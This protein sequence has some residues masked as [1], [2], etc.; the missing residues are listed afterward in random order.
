MSDFQL[1][2]TIMNNVCIPRPVDFENPFRG[3]S[4][5]VYGYDDEEDDTFD[6]Y[7][8]EQAVFDGVDFRTVLEDILY[9]SPAVFY[10]QPMDYFSFTEDGVV[11]FHE[12]SREHLIMQL[13]YFAVKYSN[14]R[15]ME[16][17]KPEKQSEYYYPRV[18]REN[19]GLD[20]F[21]PVFGYFKDKL[22][23]WNNVGVKGITH[24]FPDPRVEPELL[25]VIFG[26][27]E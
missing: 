12:P 26:A 7:V 2:I 9:W 23:W 17:P 6:G 5:F 21:T 10:S 4:V 22:G 19:T 13:T 3:Q 15:I 8:W 24:F 20:D 18:C 1:A 27:P 14:P 25:N 16:L 11:E